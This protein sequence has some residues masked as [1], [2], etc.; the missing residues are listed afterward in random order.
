MSLD[1]LRDL[2]LLVGAAPTVRV[3]EVEKPLNQRAG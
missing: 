1:L 3:K 2:G